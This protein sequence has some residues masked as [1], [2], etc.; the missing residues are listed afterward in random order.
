MGV[1]SSKNPYHNDYSS[2]IAVDAV[3]A[4]VAAICVGLRFY[5]RR[6]LQREKPGMDD[7]LLLAGLV[8]VNCS[9][10]SSCLTWIKQTMFIISNSFDIAAW[11][12]RDSEGFRDGDPGHLVRASVSIP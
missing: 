2:I 3:T 6:V 5:V 8:R 11:V 10:V 4:A 1:T 12:R 9:C 7:W